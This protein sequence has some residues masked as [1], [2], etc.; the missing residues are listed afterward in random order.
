VSPPSADHPDESS[1]PPNA[2]GHA[3][4][5][6]QTASVPRFC[7][8]QSWYPSYPLAGPLWGTPTDLGF[9]LRNPFAGLPAK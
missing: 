6:V 5:A 7:R 4:V 1:D 8:R 2:H 9:A 3:Y